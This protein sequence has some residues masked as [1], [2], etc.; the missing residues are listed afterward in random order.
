MIV[1]VFR[2]AVRGIPFPAVPRGTRAAVLGLALAGLLGCAGRVDVERETAALAAVRDLHR[3]AHFNAD[4]E[5]LVSTWADDFRSIDSGAVSRPSKR[6]SVA[7]FQD[8]LSN[9]TFVAWDDIDPPIV[10]I[11][12]DG[13]MA[14]VIV[15]KRVV[16]RSRAA[17]DTTA[18]EE[19]TFAWLETWEKEEGAWK[20][21]ALASTRKG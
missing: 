18:A 3:Q 20:L 17:A 15:T 21:K 4:A 12:G 13:A 7:G 16:L 1:S 11:S 8:Y 10:R 6:E 9:S 2:S 19:S 14:Y 5:L